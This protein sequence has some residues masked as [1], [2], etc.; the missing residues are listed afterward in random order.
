VI[1]L[2]QLSSALSRVSPIFEEA[3]LAMLVF[4]KTLTG[5]TIHLDVEPSDTIEIVK[6]MI[7][8]KEGIATDQ[9]RIIFAGAQLKD[10]CTLSDYNVQKNDILHLVLRLRGQGDMF[11]NHVE[12]KYP[13]SYAVDVSVTTCIKMTFDESIR[14]VTPNGLLALTVHADDGDAEDAIEIAHIPL[15]IVYD[16]ASRTVTAVPVRPLEWGTKY[17]IRVDIRR[18]TGQQGALMVG[19]TPWT[20]TSERSRIVQGLKFAYHGETAENAA[21]LELHLGVEGLALHG[22]TAL[23]LSTSPD[24]IADVSLAHFGVQVR[25]VSD[26]LNIQNGD[27]IGFTVNATAAAKAAPGQ[28]EPCLLS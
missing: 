5:K 14:S 12:A 1:T 6:L 7:N 27:T 10:Y 2:E 9:Q 24:F 22:A 16:R 4:V 20:F 25:S 26:L 18:V 23:G 17:E 11:E 28:V 15:T 21:P 3:T 8:D 13:A 19:S